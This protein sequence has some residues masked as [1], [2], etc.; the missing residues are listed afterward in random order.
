MCDGLDNNCDGNIDEGVLN[1][2]Y[3]DTDSDGYGDASTTTQACDPPSGYVTDDTDCDDTNG[4]VN[5]GATEDCFDGIDNDCDG[6][7]DCA[8]CV[9]E[10]INF[11]DF[12]NGLSIWNDGGSDCALTQLNPN[13]GLYSL[14][15]RDNTS[16]SVLT[17]DNLDLSA[18]EELTVEFSYFPVS[19]D[20]S[21]EDFWLQISEDGGS[22][23]TLVEEWNLNDEFV[24]NTRY[25]E[26]IFLPGPFTSTNTQF[27]FRCDASGNKD[28]IYLDD[29]HIRGCLMVEIHLLVRWCSKWE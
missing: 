11:S 3:A 18:Y 15:I 2:Y 25:D 12:E 7:V 19:M 26:S 9:Y 17:T 22:T 24:N 10:T 29:I 4:S 8:T 27:R 1:T 13:S 20:N 16:E 6:V 21:S 23:F 5:P 14:E 28:W